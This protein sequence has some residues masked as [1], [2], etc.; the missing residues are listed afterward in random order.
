MKDRLLVG[1]DLGTSHI[2][3]AV[4]QLVVAQDKR[5]SLQLIGAAE[6][7]S[8]GISKGNI[9]SLEDAVSAISSCLEQ[10]ERVIGLPI[11]E[12]TVGIGG[13][14]I[15]TQLAKGVIGV[16]RPDGD[17]RAEDA[18]RAI[19][20]ARAFVNPANQEILHVLPRSY[21]V[22]G[23]GGI[24]DPVGMHGIRLEVEAQIVQGLS[25]HIRNLTKAVFR[26]GLDISELVY[27]PLATAEAVAT[28]R[29]RELGVCVISIGASTSGLSIFEDGELLHA[30][31][32]PI[33]ADHITSD[34]AI[35]LRIS[36][37]AAERI[38]RQCGTANAEELPKRGEEID[39]A[40]F[41]A[42]QSELVPVRYVAEIIEARVEEIFEKVDAE[43]K[44]IARQGMLPA[45]V[46]L[47]GGGSKLPGVVEVAKRMLRLP[48]SLGKMTMLSSMP[49]VISDP[50]FSTAVGLVL[51]SYERERRDE[52]DR[53]SHNPR[54]SG[55]GHAKNVLN[56][57]KSPL[58][59]LFRS[60]IP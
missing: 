53:S 13:T 37:E 7:A 4:G 59:K 10:A 48:C 38:K 44:R 23:Q 58:S 16:S 22:D 31:T 36:L 49:E 55:G 28:S 60:F 52:T 27:M 41:G 15:T 21:S 33:G 20:A 57:V 50:A 11:S 9:T 1:L 3:I 5:V 51:W 54:T 35:G 12:A 25:S 2:R 43:L 26:T 32:L 29:D 14:S 46:I 40:Q 42:E 17:V 19:E 45:G 24:K 47:T 6:A 39:V 8:Q 56:K 18:A 30:V 34:I